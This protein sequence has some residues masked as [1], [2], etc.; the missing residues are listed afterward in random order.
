MR[1]SEGPWKENVSPGGT[2]AAL[3]AGAAGA[4][5]PLG[6][7]LECLPPAAERLGFVLELIA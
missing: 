4:P 2:S 3:T 6:F 1:R 5:D 7:Y